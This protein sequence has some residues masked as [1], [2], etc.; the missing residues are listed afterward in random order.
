MS[1]I[2][3]F[4]FFCFKI[5]LEEEQMKIAYVKEKRPYGHILSLRDSSTGLTIGC[6]VLIVM[7]DTGQETRQLRAA[8]SGFETRAPV[9]GITRELKHLCDERGVTISSKWRIAG[10]V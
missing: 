6:D 1:A 2:L 4:L 5:F 3:T 9:A 10:D 8:I 7:G